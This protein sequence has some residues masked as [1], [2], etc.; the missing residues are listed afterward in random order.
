MGTCCRLEGRYH[1]PLPR[2][3]ETP[4]PPCT[5]C[6]R[7]TSQLRRICQSSGTVTDMSQRSAVCINNNTSS[8]SSAVLHMKGWRRT[9]HSPS[10]QGRVLGFSLGARPVADSGVRIPGEGAETPSPH[11]LRGLR[12]A[13]SSPGGFGVEPR[14]SKGFPLSSALRMASPDSIMLLI[15]D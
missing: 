2:T 4:A 3:A 6:D 5:S 1:G 10:A 7:I 15:V 14:P 9:G 13:V 12:S 8:L 11:Q